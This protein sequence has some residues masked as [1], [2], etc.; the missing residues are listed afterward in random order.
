MKPYLIFV[1]SFTQA[2]FRRIKFTPK[3]VYTKG[4]N[5]QIITQKSINFAF[6]L[7]KFTLD[8][9]NLHRHRRWCRWQIWGMVG[10]GP[11]CYLGRLLLESWNILSCDSISS[12]LVRQYQTET[13]EVGQIWGFSR[14]LEKYKI[15]DFCSNV[16]YKSNFQ[17]C[18]FNLHL[19]TFQE[20]LQLPFGQK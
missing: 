19:I 10:G 15:G 11:N 18:N 8:R 1:I 16:Q 2:K 17:R 7:G 20:S 9:N 12:F 6:I 5:C 13:N 4:V 14:V 3:N